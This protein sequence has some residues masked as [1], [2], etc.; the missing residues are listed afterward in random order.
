VAT[1]SPGTPTREGLTYRY[2]KIAGVIGDFRAIRSQI[3][4]IS[5]C[6]QTIN[7]RTPRRRREWRTKMRLIFAAQH[8]DCALRH[9]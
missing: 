3:Q 5:H 1:T 4:R 6:Y 2:A 8:L 7:W 9:L